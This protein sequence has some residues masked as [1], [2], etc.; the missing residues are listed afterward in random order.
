M[1][2]EGT[3]PA[4]I[5]VADENAEA[6]LTAE[7]TE[8]LIHNGLQ[9]REVSILYRTNQYRAE[10]EN[11]LIEREIPYSILKNTSVFKKDGPFLALCLQAW[12][13]KDEWEQALLINYIGRRNA[14][15]V[16]SLAREFKLS[17]LETA[18]QEGI[19]RPEINR[20]VDLL[21]EDLRE[22]Q[23]HRD[24]TPLELAEAAWEIVERRGFIVDLRE[25]RG[26]LRIMGR[27]ET[28]GELISRI[29]TLDTLSQA[30][31]GKKVHLSTIHR[32]KGLEHRAVI[33]LGCV[34]G[35]LPLQVREEMNTTEE[36]RL[37][38]VA[39]TRARDLFVAIAPQTVYGEE[40]VPSRFLKEMGLKQAKW[41]KRAT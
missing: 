22:V 26:L 36:R 2:E 32:A 13:P 33:L 23:S 19:R 25:I 34:E 27:F 9:P 6:E 21:H 8:E 30:P 24:K 17:P 10:I 40:A 1:R 14:A 5:P 15:E 11:E 20:A 39:L 35:I 41:I 16:S 12:R 31:R 18:V 4:W 28:L 29:E 37:A 3:D 7:I 38:Y